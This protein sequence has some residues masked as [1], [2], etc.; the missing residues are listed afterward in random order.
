MLGHD[1]E[2]R[3]ARRGLIWVMMAL[4][5]AGCGAAPQQAVPS[6]TPSIATPSQG[7]SLADLG[8][9]NSV[10][11]LIWLPPGIQFIRQADQPNALIVTGSVSQGSTVQA[12]LRQTLEPLGWTITADAPGALMFEQ[13]RWQ[14]A[15][16]EGLT[17]WGLTVRDD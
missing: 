6:P 4:T 17:T 3:V 2:V 13:G 11:E 5:L 7:Q 14:G 15:Y 12:Y 8:W 16:A 1:Q 9:T 10:A